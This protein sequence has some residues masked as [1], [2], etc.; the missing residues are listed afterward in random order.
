LDLEDQSGS[1]DSREAAGAGANSAK[2]ES[3][4]LE[5]LV[6]NAMAD[7]SRELRAFAPAL[8][9]LAICA[10]INYV[11][12]GNLS[13]AAPLLKDELRISAS[14]LGILLSAFFWTYTALQFVSGW[15]VDSFDAN[16]VIAA[17]FL[18]WSLTTAATGLVRG[19]TMLLA[20]RLMLGGGE[21]VM[22]PACS[23]ILG[24]HLPEHHRGFANGVLQGAWSFGPAVGTLGAGLLMA[25]S[26]VFIG[27]GLTS[28][29]WLPAWIKW[30][31]RAGSMERSIDAAPGF[32]DILRQRSFWGVCAGHFSVNYL[33]YFMLTWLPF[34][35]VRER[36]LSMQSMAK[37]ASAYYAV[38]GLSATT[39]GWFSDFFIRRSYTPTLVRKSA[40]AIG[41]TIA[42]IALAGCAM[43]TTQ[44]YLLCLIAVGIGCGTARAGPFAFSQT[45]AG[46]HATGKWTDLQNGFA[47]LSGV[48]APALTGL[49]V[50]RT[51]KFL[52]PLAIAAAVLVT[53]GLAWVFAV[54]PVEQVSWESESGEAPVA[55]ASF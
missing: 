47:N 2:Q 26:L 31:P 7:K 17:G 48:V 4:W 29:A 22:I 32:A 36:H 37:V 42:A 15:M 28:L 20:M 44:W 53:G 51:G 33:A 41:H 24:F 12:R 18:L 38:E 16:R 35:L 55:T 9:L 5:D 54:G 6:M 19:F 21:S 11:D 39:T 43:A 46:S 52:A 34:Y 13:I 14:Q 30:M 25:T 10:L 3:E 50:D 49:L 1:V 23:K 45:L 8:I 27:I 40:M